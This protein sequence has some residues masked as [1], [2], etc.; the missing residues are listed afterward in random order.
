M[1]KGC[2]IDTY[3]YYFIILRGE[4]DAQFKSNLLNKE[5]NAFKL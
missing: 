2:V 4:K 5:N 1:C 3:V